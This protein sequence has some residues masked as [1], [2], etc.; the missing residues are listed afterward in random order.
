MRMAAQR[1][2]PI[3]V[4]HLIS[5]KSS[6]VNSR[7]KTLAS[8]R[9][10]V[11][12][13]SMAACSMKGATLARRLCWV[14]AGRLPTGKNCIRTS[15]GPKRSSSPS[16]IFAPRATGRPFRVMP[17]SG[18]NSWTRKWPLCRV[19][20]SMTLES[21]RR[22]EPRRMWQPS[23]GPMRTRSCESTSVCR[24][25]PFAMCTTRPPAIKNENSSGRRRP[26]TKLWRAPLRPGFK[27]QPAAG[28][29]RHRARF[30]ITFCARAKLDGTVK[31]SAA[32]VMQGLG[33][34]RRLRGI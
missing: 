7:R 6:R 14:T 33:R 29:V 2:A 24:S 13:A 34:G 1:N 19:S 11:A 17:I 22:S 27:L 20:S 25:D 16:S 26:K 15:K 18:S 5:R 28:R 31:S 10:A 30:Y 8:S 3:F 12:A 9:R 4:L 23:P 21:V 32:Y